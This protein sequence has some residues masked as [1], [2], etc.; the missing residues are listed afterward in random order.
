MDKTEKHWVFSD[1][2]KM[3]LYFL[4]E[5]KETRHSSIKEKM[6]YFKQNF[7]DAFNVSMKPIMDFYKKRVGLS[8]KRIGIR[9][10]KKK[11]N[12]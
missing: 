1:E 6:Y 10:P 3:F 2:H 8:Y 5:N 12:Y 11:I 7:P 4:W 9:E